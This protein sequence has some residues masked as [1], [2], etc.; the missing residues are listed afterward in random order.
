MNFLARNFVR[1]L[2]LVVPFTVTI[3][4]VYQI[5]TWLDRLIV[6][7]YPGLGIALLLFGTT[8]IGITA[9]SFVVRKLL[10]VPEAIF[11][12]AP[13]VRIIYTSMR[14]LTDAFVGDQKKFDRPVL[15][16]LS[17][18]EE[19]SAVGFLTSEDL[20]FLGLRDQV[21]V[22]LPQS[23]NF[24]GNLLV[25]PSARVRRLE[26]ESSRAMAFAVSGGVAGGAAGTSKRRA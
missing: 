13:I 8:L 17:S 9:S 1:G 12:R 25:V 22:Y 11:S 6:V 4:V 24:A 20:E 15:V 21:A 18:T 16:E 26:I 3:Y 5:L 14:D 23:Y 2:A 10:A 7:P 19:L